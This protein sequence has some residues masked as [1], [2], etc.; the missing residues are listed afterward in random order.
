MAFHF[1]LVPIV[2]HRILRQVA[3]ARNSFFQGDEIL[4]HFHGKADGLPDNFFGVYEDQKFA[5]DAGVLGEINLRDLQRETLQEV[6][7]I[8]R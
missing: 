6:E 2:S 3:R 1:G 7:P 4:S 5:L 8:Q